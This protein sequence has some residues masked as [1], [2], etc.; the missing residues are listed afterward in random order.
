MVSKKIRGAQKKVE[1]FHFEQRKNLLEYD[2]VMD[3][4][5]KRIYGKRNE[6]LR[7]RN[8][9]IEIMTMIHDQIE[10][11][12]DRYLGAAYGAESFADIGVR[13]FQ[14]LGGANHRNRGRLLIA[15]DLN[16]RG[17]DHHLLNTG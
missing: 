2:E 4:Q 11:A 17:G 7:D 12:V 13:G 6:I 3:T 5:R 16:A 15:R 9:R 1:E 10:A 8:C 14:E